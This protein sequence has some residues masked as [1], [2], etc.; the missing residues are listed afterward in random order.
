M[1][2]VLALTSLGDQRV[3]DLQTEDGPAAHTLL[4]DVSWVVQGLHPIL[5]PLSS[6]WGCQ[7]LPALLVLI[8]GQNTNM[9]VC[10]SISHSSL[11]H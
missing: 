10:F 5:L 1:T 6:L 9:L 4:R 11:H 7:A 3:R 8:T 2:V